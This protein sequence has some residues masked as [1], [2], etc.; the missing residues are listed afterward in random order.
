MKEEGRVAVV[1]VNFNGAAHIAGCLEALRRQS[2]SEFFCVV[3]DNASTDGSDEVVESGFPDVELVRSSRNMGFA[4][5]NNMVIERCLQRDGVEFVLTL[6]NDIAMEPD[7]LQKMVATMDGTP[8]AWSCQPKMYLFRE[9]EG[10][11]VLNSTGILVWRDG[12]AFNRGINEPDHGQYDDARDIFGTCAGCSLYRASALRETGLFDESFF[13][14]MEDVD[15]AW[16]GR[17]LY[18]ESVLCPEAVCWHH[19]GASA[20]DPS[21]KIELVEANRVRVL[22]KD[23]AA[24]DILTSPLF[25]AYRLFL[26]A[27]LSRR[28][29]GGTTRLDSYRSGLGALRLMKAVLKG[30]ARGIRDARVCLEY[31]RAMKA[32]GAPRGATA[33]RLTRKYTSPLAELLSR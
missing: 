28:K 22:L 18:Y 3:L 1:I 2:F 9:H 10:A 23:Y 25:T 30:W 24:S 15:L 29:S 13:A 32:I 7:C 5:G 12:S 31:R 4:A 8:S 17:L 11:P 21:R 6:N 33:R 16:R 19:H 20:T 26:L 27:V 14:Y